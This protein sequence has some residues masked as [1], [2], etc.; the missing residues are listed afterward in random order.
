MD[1]KNPLFP[2]TYIEKLQLKRPD[3]CF[4]CCL[5]LSDLS[6]LNL[7][8][9]RSLFLHPKELAYFDSLRFERRQKSF[10]LGRFCA[11][12]AL[13]AFL[14][15]SDMTEISVHHGVFEHP[16]V[17]HSKGKVVQI[18]ISHCDHCGGAIAFPEE[19]PMAI[20]LEKIDPRKRDV[21][22]TQCT[23]E[24]FKLIQSLPI[25][26]TNQLTLL[27]TVKESLSKVLKCGLM[28]PFKVFEVKEVKSEYDCF[29]WT[30]RK[31]A[32]YKAISF[33]IGKTVCSIITPKKTEVMID[34]KTIKEKFQ[35]SG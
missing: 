12:Q 4:E 20:D 24:E 3:S 28:T 34:I 16:I 22:L 17:R 1:I 23:P 15:E 29:F 19:H 31:F 26:E 18:S 14:Q 7:K 2:N 10:L 25:P 35:N 21:I 8:E 11:K 33:V 9:K 13:S 27:W 32:Q 30:F 6:F 5:C